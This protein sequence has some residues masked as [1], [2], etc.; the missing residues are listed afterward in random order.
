MQEIPL[1]F[2]ENHGSEFEKTVTMED[3]DGKTLAMKVGGNAFVGFG[4][5]W[6]EFIQGYDVKLG[7]TIAVFTLLSRSRFLI[8]VY[9]P[10]GELL[11][12]SDN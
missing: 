5:E 8:Q 7:Q 4:F 12:E 6:R 11:Y 1:I 9:E 10:R 2:V 3:E